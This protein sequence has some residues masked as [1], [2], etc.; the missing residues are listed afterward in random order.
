MQ[1]ILVIGGSKF[2]GKRLLRKL[3]KEDCK[4]T[5]LNRGNTPAEKYLPDNATH[6]AVDRN[7]KERLNEILKDK[8][9]DVVYDI[10][11]IT[12]EHAEIVIEALRGKVKRHVHISSGSVYQLEKPTDIREVPIDEDQPLATITGDTHP[13]IKAKTEAELAFFKVFEEENYPI[14]IVRP[15][16]VYGPDNYVYREA[17]FFDRISRNRTILLP[18]D[19]EG[20][21]DMVYVDDLVD[22]ITHIGTYPDDKVLGQA[23]NGSS[24][25]LMSANM[26]ARRVAEM[27]GKE[28]DI[29]YYPLSIGEDLD[30]PP[31]RML[32]PYV[33]V[34]VM[35][36]SNTK[37]ERDLGFIFNT[38]YDEGLT[39]AFNWW[40]S[41]NYEEPDWAIENLLMD[42]LKQFKD[43]GKDHPAVIKL[44]EEI[45]ANNSAFIAETI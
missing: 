3:G 41:E 29:E 8:N 28:V 25:I 32:Y 16:Y 7:D 21:F 42:Y 19:G 23:Y 40:K 9:F 33:P 17:Y 39:N 18:E 4:I 14:S 38:G 12:G 37:A 1:N 36:F 30:W 11:C 31:E 26:Y 34:G 5:V 43:K 15:T 44:A 20:Y 45:K 24:A 27:L 13:Y 35:S 22:L 6:I 2:I 10:S